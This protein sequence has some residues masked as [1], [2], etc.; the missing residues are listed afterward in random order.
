MATERGGWRVI[1]GFL[2]VLLLAGGWFL[3]SWRVQH[4]AVADALGEAAGVAFA[5][6]VVVSVVGAI[7]SGRRGD[8]PGDEPDVSPRQND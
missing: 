2:G 5:L 3:L 6:L 8:T 7:V 4:S 1:V